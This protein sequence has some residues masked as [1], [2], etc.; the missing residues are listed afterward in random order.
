[1]KLVVWLCVCL[2]H[3]IALKFAGVTDHVRL[4]GA[5]GKV[6]GFADLNADKATDILFQSGQCRAV[7]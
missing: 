4:G 6:V 3:C 1:M 5:R 7:T 2:T